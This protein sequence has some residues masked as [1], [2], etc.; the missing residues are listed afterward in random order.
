MVLLTILI[1]LY[2]NVNLSIIIINLILITILTSRIVLIPAHI[3][4]CI[5][6]LLRRRVR[7]K[8]RASVA[9]H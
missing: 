3:V 8:M 7:C 5:R 9:L 4:G 1:N 6:N 2:V